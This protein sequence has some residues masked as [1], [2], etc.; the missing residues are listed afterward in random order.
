MLFVCNCIFEKI[1]H[2]MI[3]PLFQLQ[4]SSDT[5]MD[6]DLEA[7]ANQVIDFMLENFAHLDLDRHSIYIRTVSSELLCIFGT[8][9]S[10][11][12][13]LVWAEIECTLQCMLL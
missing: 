3:F 2:F 7:V 10:C 6:P 4:A 9:D 13:G 12:A 1:F 8:F 11:L 5:E